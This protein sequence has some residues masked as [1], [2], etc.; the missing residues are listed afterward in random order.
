[1]NIGRLKDDFGCKFPMSFNA[2]T[3]IV[4]VTYEN[5]SPVD[6]LI[7]NYIVSGLLFPGQVGNVIIIFLKYIYSLLSCVGVLTIF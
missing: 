4:S 5:Y 2:Q 1:M 7:V 6:L 3:Q